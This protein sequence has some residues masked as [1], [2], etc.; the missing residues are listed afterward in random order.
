MTISIQAMPTYEQWKLI[1]VLRKATP[2]GFRCFDSLRVAGAHVS[3]L[4]NLAEYG[5]IGGLRDGHPVD[6]VSPLPGAAAL[7]ADLES[8]N[9]FLTDDG[10]NWLNRSPLNKILFVLHANAGSRDMSVYDV[11]F[12]VGTTDGGW[13]AR[14]ARTGLIKLTHAD[15]DPMDADHLGGN[16][17]NAPWQRVRLTERG[18][19]LTNV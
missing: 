16:I 8:V 15:G 5:W 14:L 1:Q 19:A 18:I 3:D 13:F 9:L 11:A 10:R 4:P 17:P 7:S 6:L 12:Q 2:G